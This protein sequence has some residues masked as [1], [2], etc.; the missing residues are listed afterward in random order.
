MELNFPYFIKT[1]PLP[2]S[3]ALFPLYEAISN[4]IDAINDKYGNLSEGKIDITLYRQPQLDESLSEEAPIQSIKISDNGIGFTERNFQAFKKISTSRKQSIGGKGLGRLTWLKVFEYAFIESYYKEDEKQKYV[5]FKFVCANEAIKDV[6]TITLDLEHKNLTEITLNNCNKNY[7]GG[8]GIPKKTDTLANRVITHFIPKFILPDTPEINIFEDGKPDINLNLLFTEEIITDDQRTTF[9]I[10]G[11]KFDIVHLK[12]KYDSRDNNRHRVYYIADGRVVENETFSHEE[13]R[14]I[15]ERLFNEEDNEEYV[16][17]GYVESSFLNERVN[18]TRDGFTLLDDDEERLFIEPTKPQIRQ[19]VFKSVNSF[20]DDFIKQTKTEKEIKI[21]E[22]IHEKAPEYNYLLENHQENLNNITLSAI[23]KGRLED[24][25]HRIHIQVKNSI[26]EKANDLLEIPDNL[27]SVGEYR[28]KFSDIINDLD[29]SGRAELANYIVY[30]KTVLDLLKKG[31]GLQDNGKYE[32][33]EVIHNYICPT[34]IS[35]NDIGYQKHNLWL[36]DERLAFNS[37]LSSDQPLSSIPVLEITSDDYKQK[38][39]DILSIVLATVEPESQPSPYKTLDIIEF[40]RPMRD[41]Y[42]SD[43][44]PISQVYDYLRVIRSSNAKSLD[45]R[46]VSMINGGIIYAH[47][48]CDITKNLRDILDD[49]DYSQIGEL[50]WF[51]HFQD[52]YNALIEVKSF[53]LM[54]DDA[55]RKNKI[56]FDKLGIDRK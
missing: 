40:K 26:Q 13:V 39:P 30:R 9:E 22:Y 21:K 48:I 47:I 54:V 31:L 29:P 38:R 42:S 34:R 25:L 20:L 43:E 11:R 52:S 7:Q 37:Y 32:K 19:E 53:D 41:D 14:D 6:E 56:L 5:S 10:S 45:G 2:Y 4:S 8:G 50:D 23:N 35:S 51:I 33:E 49:Y 55:Y 15:P 3:Q 27:L 28:K 44:N 36:L 17:N 46:P 24:E 12:S 18:Q 1:S 16:Y